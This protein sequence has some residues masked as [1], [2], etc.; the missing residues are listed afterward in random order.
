MAL[1]VHSAHAA[2]DYVDAHYRVLS[3]PDCVNAS[4]MIAEFADAPL[5]TTYMRVQHIGDVGT[6]ELAGQ[7]Q[8]SVTWDVGQLTG[9]SLQGN[10]FPQAQ[11]G[12]RDI[13][14]PNAASAFQ[15]WCNGAGFYLNSRQFNHTLPLTLEGPSVSVA[16]DFQPGLAP[17]S[18]ATS[19]LTFD[20][21]IALPV[22]RFGV[23]VISGKVHVH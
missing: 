20:A 2:T 12:Y 15:L 17:F 4:Q 18:N 21:T 23:P 22:V 7:I 10:I 9:L 5:N 1:V 16:R 3:A 8:N 6:P 14:P 13:G 19:A 11:R